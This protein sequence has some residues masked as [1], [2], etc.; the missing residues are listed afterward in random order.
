MNRLLA[1]LVAVLLAVDLVTLTAVQKWRNQ[2]PAPDLTPRVAQL[3][4]D[5]AQAQQDMGELKQEVALL[6]RRGQPAD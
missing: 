4:K 2:P 5:V 3:E 1:L 6:A